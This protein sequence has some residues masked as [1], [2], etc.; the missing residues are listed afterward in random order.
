M[1]ERFDL[2]SPDLVERRPVAPLDEEQEPGHSTEQPILAL[3]SQA[4]RITKRCDDR[5]NRQVRGGARTRDLEH[6]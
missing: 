6:R 4:T 5:R 2:R 1:H 3:A